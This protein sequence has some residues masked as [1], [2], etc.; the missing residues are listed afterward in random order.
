MEH[1]KK[2]YIKILNT[3][4]EY[5]DTEIIDI[6]D[7]YDYYALDSFELFKEDE[8]IEHKFID[9]TYKPKHPDYPI[10]VENGSFTYQ[11]Q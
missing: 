7:Y 2:E 5:I 4:F 1:S 11:I 6:I 10:F 9:R 3:E 8:L